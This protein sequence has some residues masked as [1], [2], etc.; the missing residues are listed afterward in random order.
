MRQRGEKKI[1]IPLHAPKV[2]RDFRFWYL[3]L[4]DTQTVLQKSHCCVDFCFHFEFWFLLKSMYIWSCLLPSFPQV[5]WAGP[6]EVVKNK[7]FNEHHLSLDFANISMFYF[8]RIIYMHKIIRS[9]SD[10]WS[11][12]PSV[13]SLAAIIELLFKES[14]WAW[15]LSAVCSPSI[16][17]ASITVGLEIPDR[18]SLPCPFKYVFMDL[19]PMNTS[20]AFLSLLTLSACI[21]SSDSRLQQFDP[22]RLKKCFLLWCTPLLCQFPWCPLLLVL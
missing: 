14:T 15:L 19:L 11:L 21:A 9:G 10:W 6:K 2:L 20:N 18:S 5:I 22:N 8:S 17:P 4:S 12:S 1:L 16:H 13:L 7:W 3:A